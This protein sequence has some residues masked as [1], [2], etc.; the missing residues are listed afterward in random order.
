MEQL[1]MPHSKKYATLFLLAVAAVA[2]SSGTAAA[3]ADAPTVRRLSVDEAVQLALEQNLGIAVERLNPQIQDMSVAQARSYWTPTFTTGMQGNLQDS[4]VTNALAGGQNKISDRRFT[5]QVGVTQILPTGANYSLSWNGQRSTTNNF[6][7]NFNPLLNSYVAFSVTQPLLRNRTID[8]YRQQLEVSRKDRAAAD[9]SL[10]ATTALTTRN[11]KNAYWDLAYAREN[12][13]TQQQSLDLAKRAL[14][15]NEKRVQIGTMAPIDIVEAQSEVARNEESVIV[16]EAA[17]K[18]AEDRLRAL[19]FNPSTPDFWTMTIEPSQS[20]PFAPIAV[21]ADAAIRRAIGSRTDVQLARNSIERSEVNL[22]FFRSQTLPEVNA[23][24][25]Y[26]A[27]AVG[28]TTLTPLTS[29]PP[30]SFDRGILNQRSF[31]TVLGDVFSN[32]FPTWTF[33]LSVSYPIGASTQ[34]TNYSRATLQYQQA[35]KQLQNLELQIATQVRDAA[36]QVQTNQKR[37][38]SARA[39][40]DLAEQR[41]SAEEKKFAAG[42]QT[43]FFVF[44]AQR[45]LA[46]ARTNEVRAIADFNKSVVDFEAIQDTSLT[47]N[48]PIT[49]AA[50]G[51]NPLGLTGVGGTVPGTTPGTTTTGSTTQVR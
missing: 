11:V 10:Q 4:P 39:A 40:R 30:T 8:S 47:G 33:G 29:F 9:V 36:R 51:T 38:D 20:M 19:I 1:S 22:K 6:F 16:A 31:G 14:A 32:A 28:G 49:S 17:I 7:T 3:Q 35:Q 25:N 37:V 18:Q 43:S 23:S 46:Q 26:Q 41:L 5:S 27:T 12:L 21:D 45:D 2:A 44:Q 34:E 48:T 50:T 13:R 15:D 24:L 42:I